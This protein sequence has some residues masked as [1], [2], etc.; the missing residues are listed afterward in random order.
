M[1]DDSLTGQ[2]PESIPPF[3]VAAA[4]ESLGNRVHLLRNLAELYLQSRGSMVDSLRVALQ[5]GNVHEVERSI[6]SL[7]GAVG[8]FR[9][10]P[11]WNITAK[12][13]EASLVGDLDTVRH[14]QRDFE[15]II[16]QLALA[17]QDFVRDQPPV[18]PRN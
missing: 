11:L 12:M 15:M 10:G 3:D 14:L 16:E 7:R 2:D 18:T 5:Q 1:D 9:A 8:Y 17:L 13:Q 4:L 6:H